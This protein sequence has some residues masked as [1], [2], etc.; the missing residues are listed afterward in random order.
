[1]AQQV[2]M[3]ARRRRIRDAAALSF[4]MQVLIST[5][6]AIVIGMVAVVVPAVL[7]AMVTRNKS[8]ILPIYI[9]MGM[10]CTPRYSHLER[11]DVEV[12]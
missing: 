4:I 7:L 11:S 12:R 9:S 2:Q 10:D 8:P 5:V 1:M 3:D 6:G